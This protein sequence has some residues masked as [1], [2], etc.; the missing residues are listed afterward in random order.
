M[1]K[2]IYADE[3]G[4]FDFSNQR[5]ASRYFILTTVAFDDHSVA[6]QLDELRRKLAWDRPDSAVGFFHATNDEQRVRDAVFEVIGEYDFRVDATILEKRK[7]ASKF[8]ND[9]PELYK[10]AWFFHMKYVAGRIALPHEEL[11][12]VA[13]AVAIKKRRE[14]FRAAILDAVG[15][16]WPANQ[17]RCAMWPSASNTSLQVAD[18]CGWAI[19]R[20]WESGDNRSY[21][22]IEN[23]IGSEFDLFRRGQRILY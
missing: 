2:Y 9:E 17:F 15:Q 3:S 12:V 23:K 8:H 7:A 16:V 19:Q 11:F 20:K 13:S 18:Y 22:L 21:E 1:R 10:L 4:N 14:V 5:G 6:N